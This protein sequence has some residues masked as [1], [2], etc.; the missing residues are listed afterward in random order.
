M[1]IFENMLRDRRWLYRP[2]IP[3]LKAV[4]GAAFSK[5]KLQ[6]PVLDLAC[7]DGVFASSVF[8]E[9]IE[10]GLDIDME[11]LKRVNTNY[12]AL[13]QASATTLPFKD[14]TFQTVISACAVEH[15]PDLKSTLMQAYKVLKPGGT[16][17]FSIP[18][19]MFGDMLLKTRLLKLFG[20]KKQAQEYIKKK[21]A[22]SNHIHIYEIKKW[23]DILMSCNFIPIHHEY[24]LSSDVILLWSFMTSF[25]FKLCFLPFRIARDYNIKPVDA[26]LQLILSKSFGKVIARQSQKKLSTGGYLILVA[27]RE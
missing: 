4:E 23:R 11:S 3:F 10:T 20:L 5:F 22:K 13:I 8:N 12:N 26:L 16:F 15:I 17:I 19:V 1:T 27:K 7:G 2:W 14:K 24:C 18:S 6:Q 9:K 25:V 21:N